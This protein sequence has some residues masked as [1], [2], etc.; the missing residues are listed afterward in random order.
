LGRNR[1]V[2]LTPDSPQQAWV[3]LRNRACKDGVRGVTGYGI[4]RVIT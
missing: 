4:T 3:I 1:C 2:G